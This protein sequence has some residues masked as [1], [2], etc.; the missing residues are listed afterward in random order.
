MFFKACFNKCGRCQ[1]L[2]QGMHRLV[3]QT[4]VVHVCVCVSS[5]CHIIDVVVVVVHCVVD[6][7][8][9]FSLLCGCKSSL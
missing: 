6:C 9:L 5:V 1:W 4:M 2:C 3:V 8:W 7:C